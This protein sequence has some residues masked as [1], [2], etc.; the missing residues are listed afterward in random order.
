[1][2]GPMSSRKESGGLK[3]YE[4]CLSCCVTL[5]KVLSHWKMVTTMNDPR[6][7]EDIPE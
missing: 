1:M 6:T 2:V 3:N 7:S 5:R 4:V